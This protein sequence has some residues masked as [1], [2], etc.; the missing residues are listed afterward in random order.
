MSALALSAEILR[1]LGNVPEADR[2]MMTARILREEFNAAVR[3]EKGHGV[4]W[5]PAQEI[6]RSPFPRSDTVRAIAGDF[7]DALEAVYALP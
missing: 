4:Q 6:R 2:R 7:E 5:S 3:Q 1:A